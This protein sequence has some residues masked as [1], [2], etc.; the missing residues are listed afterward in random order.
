MDKTRTYGVGRV[1]I[2]E[3]CGTRLSV[4]N[5]SRICALHG[6]GWKEEFR[7]G[8]R[9]V[10]HH[11]EMTRRCAYELCSREFL[12]TNPAKKYCSDHCRMKAFQARLLA[13][14]LLSGVH[15]QRR[16]S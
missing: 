12:T 16:A 5:P 14:R 4:Y 7:P 3:G 11:E 10:S 6:D 13:E 2:V 1:C 9:G 8:P 15:A